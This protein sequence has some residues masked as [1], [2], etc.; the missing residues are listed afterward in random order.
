VSRCSRMF[1][2]IRKVATGRSRGATLTEVVIS[3]VVL[4]FVVASVPTAMIVV[5]NMQ[6]QQD[7]RRV[8]EYLTRNQLEYI[9]SQCYHWGNVTGDCDYQ[10][11]NCQG[12][13]V[14]YDKISFTENY[15]LEVVAVPIDKDT[16][17]ALPVLSGPTGPY[18]EDQGI[19]EITIYVMKSGQEIPVL[20]TT[21]Y[22]VALGEE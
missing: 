12:Y 8:A 16:L 9:K 21:N 4:A 17:Q 10:R 1:K 11:M 6:A 7:E 13:P 5:H 18:V 3:I 20:V 14:C 19:Q 15:Y 2:A 22:K